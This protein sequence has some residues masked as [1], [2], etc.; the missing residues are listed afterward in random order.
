LVGAGESTD[1]NL[2]VRLD[3]LAVVVCQLLQ[4]IE[5]ALANE[6]ILV[7]GECSQLADARRL[8]FNQRAS[9]IRVRDAAPIA[10]A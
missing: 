6:P 10:S 4:E 1:E 5:S 8:A 9:A 7:A 2:L 3:P